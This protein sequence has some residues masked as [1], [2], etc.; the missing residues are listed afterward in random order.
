MRGINVI[1]IIIIII[2]QLQSAHMQHRLR[3]TNR[4][5]LVQAYIGVQV[6]VF[7]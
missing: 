7:V 5:T 4:P 1:I 6:N 3:T 2:T